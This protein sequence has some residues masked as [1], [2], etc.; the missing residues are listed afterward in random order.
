ML[1][2]PDPNSWPIPTNSQPIPNLLE[3]VSERGYGQGFAECAETR[4]EIID[5]LIRCLEN[6][7]GWE[8]FEVFS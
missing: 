4:H 3:Q 6:I 2:W 7:P 8:D 1:A 5:A